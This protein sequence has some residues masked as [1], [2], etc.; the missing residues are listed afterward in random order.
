MLRLPLDVGVSNPVPT[1]LKRWRQTNYAGVAV[2]SVTKLMG[3]YCENHTRVFRPQV[4]RPD[5]TANQISSQFQPR[6]NCPR[7][8]HFTGA[9]R[10]P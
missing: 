6:C 3:L 7:N 1:A 10:R 2:L 5:P 4:V 8:G 9:T